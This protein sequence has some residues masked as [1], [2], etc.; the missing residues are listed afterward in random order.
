MKNANFVSPNPDRGYLTT[1]MGATHGKRH[2]RVS[3]NPYRGYLKITMGATHGKP[4]PVF[5][6]TPTGVI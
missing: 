1:T 2:P 6:L 4:Y 5:P 3:P